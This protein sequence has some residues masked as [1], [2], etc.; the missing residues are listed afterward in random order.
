M[1]PYA[2]VQDGQKPAYSHCAAS[3]VSSEEIQEYFKTRHRGRGRSTGPRGGRRQEP[4]RRRRRLSREEHG[5]AKASDAVDKVQFVRNVRAFEQLA[6]PRALVLC[7]RWEV[8]HDTDALNRSAQTCGAS[9]LFRREEH[10]RYA[11]MS[12]IS[13]ANNLF[14][15][16]VL[17]EENGI[18][19]IRHFSCEA[20]FPA[21]ILPHKK[22]NIAGLIPVCLTLC[23]SRRTMS[24]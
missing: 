22:I 15:K 20:V 3:Y 5:I 23:V 9:T 6:K 8:E 18:F 10:L 1:L 17:D 16:F 24:G 12:A 7:V 13:P 2:A 11:A 4:R 19:P 21:A 14:Q